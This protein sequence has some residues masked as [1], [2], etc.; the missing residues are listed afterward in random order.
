MAEPIVAVENLTKRYGEFEAVKELS[1]DVR[2]GE[3]FALLGPNGAGK[4]TTIRMLMGILH[5][6]AGTAR[7][8]GFDCFADRAEVK[9]YIG[10][11]PDDPVFYDYL[12]GREVIRFVGEMHGFTK[13]EIE[14]RYAPLVARFDLTDALDEYTINYSRGMKKRL[15]LVTA[16]LHD[17][18]LLILDEPTYGLDPFGTRTVQELILEKAG[19]GKSI[20][21]STHLLDQAE[22]VSTRVGILSKGKLAAVGRL[23]ELRAGREADATLEEIFFAVAQKPSDE[24]S[25]K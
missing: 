23:E 13:G 16:L 12:T 7:I 8:R 6:T 17:P 3:I 24:D 19:E 2:E 11:L 22:R 20:F 15:A 1:F 25:Q 18:D 21:F 14:R 10:Y 4:T 9:R 5:P